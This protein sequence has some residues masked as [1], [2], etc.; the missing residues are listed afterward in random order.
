MIHAVRQGKTKIGRNED[1]I[2]S[3]AFQLLG[4]LPDEMF[5]SILCSALRGNINEV[6]LGRLEGIEFWPKWNASGIN[7]NNS[8]VEP[9]VFIRFDNMDM[10][11]EA[12]RYDH[13]GQYKAQW[14]NE[15]QAYL[16][17]YP[18]SK[19]KV[20]L[21]ALG[22]ILTLDEDHVEIG[23]E[24]CTVYKSTWTMLLDAVQAEYQKLINTKRSTRL[25][26]VYIDLIH[27]FQFHGFF[28]GEWFSDGK[29]KPI[30]FSPIS[31]N[32]F[33]R[34][35]LRFDGSK[36]LYSLNDTGD[37]STSLKSIGKWKIPVF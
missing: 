17:E 19:Q 10:I 14:Q 16:N 5:Q 31:I 34:N 32:Y 29:M 2:T 36:W 25:E 28:V 26:R 7:S 27:S 22:G 37:K 4:Y 21:W 6:T 13:K 30:G 8:F 9:D 3:S 18:E 20:V 35:Q 1:S 11:V 33:S 15:Y 12:K 24:R 23:G